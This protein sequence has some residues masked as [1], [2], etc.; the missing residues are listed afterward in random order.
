VE[1][2]YCVIVALFSFGTLFP[3]YLN[4]VSKARAQVDADASFNDLPRHGPRDSQSGAGYRFDDEAQD[5]EIHEHDAGSEVTIRRF[6]QRIGVVF[7]KIKAPVRGRGSQDL[8]FTEHRERGSWTS[9][10]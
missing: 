10:D 3:I 6:S 4:F 1:Y 7:E 9:K 5:R 2:S 8:G